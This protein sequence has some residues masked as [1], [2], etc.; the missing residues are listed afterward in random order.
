MSNDII[1]LSDYTEIQKF[2]MRIEWKNRKHE[3]KKDK[4]NQELE[5]R[6][7]QNDNLLKSM[8]LGKYKRA[9]VEK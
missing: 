6:K 5:E 4:G 7:K 3:N 1:Y 2:C 9:G 8:N